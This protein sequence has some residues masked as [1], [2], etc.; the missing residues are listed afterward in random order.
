M[1][2]NFV[3]LLVLALFCC[4]Q[5]FKMPLGSVGVNHRVRLAAKLYSKY[6]KSNSIYI[7][8]LPSHYH[9]NELGTL[10]KDSNITEYDDLRIQAFDT[11]VNESYGQV[12]FT[13][14]TFADDA[15]VLL[16]NKTVEDRVLNVFT[17][18]NYTRL[19]GRSL[20]SNI[21]RDHLRNSL[22][23]HLGTEEI[24]SCETQLYEN[25]TSGIFLQCHSPARTLR[26]MFKLN[27]F[28][29]ENQHIQWTPFK[30]YEVLLYGVFL[31]NIHQSVTMVDLRRILEEKLGKNQ[32]KFVNM[33][34]DLVTS[35]YLFCTVLV[36]LD[37]I[38][39]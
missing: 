3:L 2:T 9:D 34:Y 5:A 22:N 27:N 10:L 24:I 19:F 1:V 30:S 28:T 36:H 18:G 31:G 6:P 13:N 23:D 25:R 21:S 11:L 4:R 20:L 29:Y 7:G 14:V 39:Y 15:V 38:G 26:A 33:P 8:N 37:L 32:V 12:R 16:S 35:N 17:L